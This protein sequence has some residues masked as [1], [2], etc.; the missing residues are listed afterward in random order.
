MKKLT[1]AFVVAAFLLLPLAIHLT[2][3]YL[4]GIITSIAILAL[5]LW[6]VHAHNKWKRLKEDHNRWQSVHIIGMHPE[7]NT[8]PV[9]E[10]EIAEHCEFVPHKEV[11][12]IADEWRERLSEAK[13][14]HNTQVYEYFWLQPVTEDAAVEYWDAQQGENNYPARLSRAIIK[15]LS[16]RRKRQYD[17]NP[18]AYRKVVAGQTINS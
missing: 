5:A 3:D 10:P 16:Y 18:K 14:R 15:D 8:P 2:S 4:A 6:V 7:H 1:S 13:N 9:M 12:I 11:N 17:A